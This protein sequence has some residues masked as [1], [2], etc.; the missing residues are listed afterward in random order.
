MTT[1]LQRPRCV[2]ST[3]NAYCRS[4]A[5]C[6]ISS[7]TGQK[8]K[9]GRSDGEKANCFREAQFSGDGT[10]VVT[11]NEDHC[12]RTFVLPTNLLED[13]GES[14][15][16]AAHSTAHP[17]THVQSYA[18]Y[19]GF[20]LQDASTTVVLS[21]CQDVPISL[22]NALHFNTVH[23]TYPLVNA[24]TEAYIAPN[25]L[26]WTN[27]GRHFVAGSKDQISIFD[28]SY[29]GS[30]P[31][32]THKTAHGRRERQMYGPNSVQ[33][34]KGVV[35]ALSISHDGVLAAGTRERHIGLYAN[36]GSG[37]CLTT[38]SVAPLPGEPDHL[39]GTG[40]TQLA[41]S[42]DG[43]YL[44]V[45]ER[46]SDVIQVYDV[47]NALRRV[48]WLSERRANTTQRLGM[49]VVPTADGYEV[50]AGGTDGSVRKWTN[51]GF[52]EDEQRPQGV[53]QLHDGRCSISL[54]AQAQR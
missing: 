46:Q 34:S 21:A 43:L 29:S 41:W 20:N 28:P 4:I 33:A 37:E 36:E 40:I 7:S 6:Q 17:P 45:A 42:P 18:V 10:S 2:A 30:G 48:G 39:G 52:V 11:Q 12:L 31:M 3:G 27:D 5:E 19:P 25:S 49:D 44:L 23:A 51:P 26:A 16:L 1:T 13:T 22:N 24:T 50:W 54:R 14:H 38:F 53:L 9:H 32:A 8:R 35:T 15:T 47:R